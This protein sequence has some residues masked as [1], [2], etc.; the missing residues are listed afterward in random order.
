MSLTRIV[1]SCLTLSLLLLVGAS[2]YYYLNFPALVEQ[3]AR[4][5]LQAYGV[6]SLTY[7]NLDISHDHLGSDRL[8]IKGEYNGLA[9]TAT[10]SS[11]AVQYDWQVALL[12]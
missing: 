11:L 6:Q 10:L 4:R 3:Q 7:D 2:I 12:A 1:L 9:Y 5:S 8:Q